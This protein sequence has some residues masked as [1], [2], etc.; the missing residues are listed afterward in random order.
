MKEIVNLRNS[1]SPWAAKGLGGF[2]AFNPPPVKGS[3]NGMIDKVFVG[4]IAPPKDRASTRPI[5]G[6]P[7]VINMFR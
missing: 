4:W 1:G 6:K 5:R 3:P 2:H 7:T